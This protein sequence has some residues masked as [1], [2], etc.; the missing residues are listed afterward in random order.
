MTTVN[1]TG[2][3]PGGSAG[4]DLTGIYP[5]PAVAKLRGYAVSSAAPGNG[6]ALVWN[7]S[8]SQWEPTTGVAPTGNAGGDLSGV[9]PNPV[10]ASISGLASGTYGSA[11]QN[12]RIVVDAKGRVTSVNV[13]DITGVAPTGEAGGDLAGNYPNPQLRTIA[14]LVAGTYGSATTVGQF[15][16]DGKGRVTSVTSLTISG[17]TPSGSAGGD[18]SGTYPHPNVAKI[19][20]RSVSSS[21]P[22]AGQVLAWSGSVWEPVT[23]VTPT[24][25]A[26]GDLAGSYPNPTLKLMGVTP[27]TYGSE[28]TIPQLE[29]D[30]KG[31]IVTINNKLIS[32]TTPTGSAGGDLAGTYPNPVL[33]TTGVLEGTYGSGTQVAQLRLDSKGRVINA[34][35]VTI[36]GIAPSGNAGGDLAGTYPNPA[37]LT[38]SGLTAGTYGSSTAVPQLSV[39][40]KGRITSV[41]VVTLASVTPGGSAGGDITGTYPNPT[42]TETGVV[43]GTYGSVSGVGQLTVDEKG[44]LISAAT[45]TISGVVPGGS[46]GGDLSGTYP[47]PT[48]ARLQGRLVSNTTPALNHIL[49]WDGSQWI[50]TADIGTTYGVIPT[51]GIQLSGIDFGLINGSSPGQILRWTGSAWGLSTEG[52]SWSMNGGAATYSDI[53]YATGT[54]GGSISGNFPSGPGIKMLW[55]PQ[56][57]AFRAG[58]VDAAQWDVAN[59]GNFS[60]AFGRATRASGAHS[61]VAGGEF[62]VAS[63]DYASILGGYSNTSA[64]NFSSVLGGYANSASGLYSVAGGYYASAQHAGTFVWA[65]SSSS[66]PFVSEAANEFAVRSIGGVR[67]ETG[68]SAVSRAFEV[69]NASRSHFYIQR[70]GNIGIG[71]TTP[72]GVLHV[73]TGISDTLV[74]TAN[75]VGI[76]TTAPAYALDV[77]GDIRATTITQGS[78]IRWKEDIHTLS[79]SLDKLLRLRG[80]SFMW[81]RKNYPDKRFSEGRQIGL[82]AQEVEKVFPELVQTDPNGFKSVAYGNVVSVLIEALKEEYDTYKKKEKQLTIQEKRLDELE[83]ENEILKR[84]IEKIKAR[85]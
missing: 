9:Y 68:A 56:K 8:A 66:T 26:G 65:D 4:G 37:L 72:K 60:V 29:V 82:I 55:L 57:A 11:T 64:G 33:K 52:A 53:V 39:D 5:N 36:S 24:G 21:T 23:G 30:A 18:L 14:G 73:V 13:V 84:E 34:S 58:Y 45:L 44:R 47:A 76:G 27:G 46:A 75:K 15:S 79:Q 2:V 50:P 12:T 49:K 1:I 43:A 25:S 16:V 70:D 40:A 20:G 28:T 32:G 3:S 51:G 7:N 63:G 81:N 22:N 19:Q 35:N 83:K 85:Y 71:T 38:I 74:V 54:F 10:L 77:N 69:K 62:N 48:V 59:I 31:R 17:V 6:Q 61:V 42:L 41:N 80:V 67:F 78:D